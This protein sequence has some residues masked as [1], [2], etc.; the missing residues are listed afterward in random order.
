MF[1]QLLFAS[2]A[3]AA[4]ARAEFREIKLELMHMR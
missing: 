1:C 4:V 3:F 2:L